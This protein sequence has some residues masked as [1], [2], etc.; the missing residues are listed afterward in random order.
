[1]TID[2]EI[3]K[4]IQAARVAYDHQRELYAGPTRWITVGAVDHHGGTH[5]EIDGQGNIS[6]GPS[7]MKGSNIANLKKPASVG[8]PGH[9]PPSNVGIPGHRPP[10]NVGIPGHRP[11]SNVGIPGHR[12]PSNVGM[13][14]M[15]PPNQDGI[16]GHRPPSGQSMPG[17]RNAVPPQQ[18]Q[19]AGQNPQEKPIPG[20]PAPLKQA[21]EQLGAQ[22]QPTTPPPPGR[23]YSPNPAFGEAA[24]V[25]V[26]GN[27][28][29]PLP[30][31]EYFR[32]PNLNPEER[33]VEKGFMDQYQ[34]DPDGQADA[35]IQAMAKGMGDGPNIFATDEAKGLVKEWKGTKVPEMGPDGK[36]AVDKDGNPKWDLSPETKEYRSKYNTALHQTANALAKRAFLKYLDTVVANGPP[37]KRNILVTAGGVACHGRGTP[38]VMF[39]GT[40]K[41]VEDVVEGDKLMGPDSTERTVMLTHSGRDML[42]NVTPHRGDS[43]TANGSHVLAIHAQLRR[44]VNGVEIPYS[45]KITITVDDY[46][47]KS[48]RFKA[49]CYLYRRGIE[50]AESRVPLDPYFLGLWLGDGTHCL[51]A[52]TSADPEI[53]EFMQQ[54]TRKQPRM[55]L[56]V[57]AKPDNAASVYQMSYLDSTPQKGDGYRKGC[58]PN[59]ITARLKEAGVLR[60]KHIPQQYLANSSSVRLQ[61][62]A[63]LLDSD[64]SYNADRKSFEITTK[65]ERMAKEIQFLARSIGFQ[66]SINEKIVRNNWTGK[67]GV[68]FRLHIGGNDL[69]LIPTKIL[70]KQAESRPAERTDG[71]VSRDVRHS[72]FRVDPIGEDEFFGFTLNK[73]HLYLLGDFTVTHNSGKGFALEN[74]DQTKSLQKMAGAVWD[75]AGEQNSTE[76][77]W[78]AEECKKRGLKMHAVFVHSKP[79]ETWE[80]P[81]RGVIE[82]ANKKGRMVDA[83]AFADSYTYGAQNFHKFSQKYANDPNVHVTVLDNTRPPVPDLDENGVQKIDKKGKPAKKPDVVAI[84]SVPQE[85][86][87]M[88]PDALY[89]HCIEAL[90][91]FPASDAVKQGGSAGTRIWPETLTGGRKQ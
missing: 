44:K 17:N 85:M 68:Y 64:G 36:Q 30:P 37:E 25:G 4:R 72:S 75:T 84:P 59:P 50:F 38:V 6:K 40:L 22:Q 21:V 78:V 5:V 71:R 26:P 8:I 53:A 90:A 58:R 12:P 76:L 56:M 81:E 82:R 73:D 20:E 49:N 57:H 63:G 33:A 29:P 1:M 88:D 65:I 16:P 80:N 86:L 41:N 10:S 7:G 67:S 45:G 48:G 31:L 11:P 83:R 54:F 91:K 23:L 35:M 77:G 24:R 62:L 55:K 28:T 52:V 60:N 3:A 42:Y 87:S 34:S 61:L 19:P 74:V 9:R 66:A 32:L 2:T 47:A 13:P 69:E 46:L 79:S 43:F 27:K 14:G 51:P 18:A 39:D 15:R 89:A 70:R